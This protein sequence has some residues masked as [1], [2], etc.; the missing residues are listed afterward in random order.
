[1]NRDLYLAL[2]LMLVLVIL[3]T[4]L[5]S[6][7]LILGIAPQLMLLAV[8][9]WSLLRGPQAGLLWAVV[10]GLLLDLFSA[11]PLGTSALALILTTTSLGLIQNY[12]PVNRF[13]IPVLYGSFGAFLYLFITLLV[14]RLTPYAPDWSVIQMV[15]SY[16]LVHATLILPVYWLLFSLSRALWPRRVTIEP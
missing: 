13:L 7:W 5:L 15:P 1:M 10:A 12:L 3:Q 16:L 11:M 8:L 4:A 14:L 6:R 9:A 2:P